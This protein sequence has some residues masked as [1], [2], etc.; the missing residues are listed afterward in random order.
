VASYSAAMRRLCAVYARSPQDR[1][2]LF[3]DIFLAVWRALPAFRAESSERTWLYRIAHNVAMTWQARDRRFQRHRF[4]LEEAA[5]QPDAVGPRETRRLLLYQLV[6]RLP[7][8]ER[9]LVGLWMEGLNTTEMGEITGIRP[10]TVAVRLTRIRQNLSA[11]F[12]TSEDRN[13]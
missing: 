11:A 1:E 5:A 2:D 10:G 3:Q 4:P 7:A 13:G 6:S 12:L 9:Q 8:I